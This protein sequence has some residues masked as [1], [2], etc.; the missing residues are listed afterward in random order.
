VELA[1]SALRDHRPL[2]ADLAQRPRLELP[3]LPPRAA[4]TGTRAGSPPPPAKPPARKPPP[5]RK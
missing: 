2:A 1:L 5:A 3:T 4:V